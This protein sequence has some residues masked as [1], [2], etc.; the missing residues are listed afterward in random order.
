MWLSSPL[1]GYSWCAQFCYYIVDERKVWWKCVYVSCYL[2]LVDLLDGDRSLY[3]LSIIGFILLVSTRGSFRLNLKSCIL[4]YVSSYL[5]FWIHSWS[6]IL[7]SLIKLI[8][9]TLTLINC[10]RTIL[11]NI[12]AIIG[13]S[14]HMLRQFTNITIEGKVKAHI[15]W[16]LWTRLKSLNKSWI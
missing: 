3:Y 12:W 10:I 16:S 13:Q 15:K 7:F 4:F 5:F 1:G 9:R 8:A 11:P 14:H 2:S 6:Y